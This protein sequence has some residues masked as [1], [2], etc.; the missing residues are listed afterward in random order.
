MGLGPYGLAWA[1]GPEPHGPSWALLGPFGHGPG[2]PS[3]ALW[4]LGLIGLRHVGLVPA[5]THMA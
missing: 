4:A 1:L 5:P 2:A 3:W